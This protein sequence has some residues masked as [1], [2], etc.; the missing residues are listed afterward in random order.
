MPAAIVLRWSM[1]ETRWPVRRHPA[2]GKRVE[3]RANVIYRMAGGKIA[4]G[5]AQMDQLGMLRQIGIDP[6][7]SARQSRPTELQPANRLF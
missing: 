2:T 5:W 1:D 3:Q 6:L 7:A 4:E